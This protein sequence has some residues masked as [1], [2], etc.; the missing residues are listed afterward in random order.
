MQRWI[1]ST[2]RTPR[3]LDANSLDNFDDTIR[4]LC[5][6]RDGRRQDYSHVN[7]KRL[8]LSGVMLD[9]ANLLRA[10]LNDANLQSA[11]LERAHLQST[12]ALGTDFSNAI[13]T[14]ACIQ[15]WGIN[16][17]TSFHRCSLRLHLPGARP[18]GASTCQR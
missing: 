15:N 14:G 11:N 16:A 2:G 10:N 6:S 13:L 9:G 12:Q 7:L 1:L 8:Y 3:L 17:D 5:T 18:T 4:L